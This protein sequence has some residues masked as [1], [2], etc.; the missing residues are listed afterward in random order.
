MTCYE[1]F[2]DGRPRASGSKKTSTSPTR[3]PAGTSN[4]KRSRRTRVEVDP[5]AS[6]EFFIS[7]SD[8]LR[9]GRASS[10]PAPATQPVS[11]EQATADRRRILRETIAVPTA[12]PAPAPATPSDAVPGSIPY[13]LQSIPEWDA[14]FSPQDVSEEDPTAVLEEH[15]RRY[16]NSVSCYT[17]CISRLVADL[18]IIGRSHADLAS[19]TG[20]ISRRACS[21]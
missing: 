6:E 7:A 10:N 3:M 13:T 20:P 1:D 8:A 15:A 2:S 17:P 19:R 9:N 5:D 18:A 4:H 12:T 11:L 14:F 21:A 16:L